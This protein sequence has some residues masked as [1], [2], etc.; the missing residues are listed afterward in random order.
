MS[1]QKIPAY[2]LQKVTASYDDSFETDLVYYLF[3]LHYG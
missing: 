2:E 1:R 3:Q